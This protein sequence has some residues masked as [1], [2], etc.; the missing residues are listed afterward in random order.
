M[1][2]AHAHAGPG[3]A[4]RLV[5]AAPDHPG[6][7]APKLLGRADA[8]PVAGM[9]IRLPVAD[10]RHHLQVLGVTGTG[11]STELLA[12][13]LAEAAAGRGFALLD[14]K[15]DLARDLLA[16]LPAGAGRRLVLID[17]DETDAPAALNVLDTAGRSPELVAEHV[18]G[19]LHRLYGAYWGPRVEDTLRAAILTLTAH[20][21][22]AT[23]ADVPR[24][25]TDRRFR[26]R[27]AGPARADDPD[28][29]GAFWDAFDALSPA[30]AAAACGPVLSKLRAV[31]TRPFA[32]DLFGTATSTF[33]PREI[34]DGGILIARLPKGVIGEDGARLVGSLLLAALWQ[35][36]LARA[37][38]P[39]HARLDA[40]VI[41]DECHNFLHL[42]IGIDDALAEARGL[43][44]SFVLAHQHLGQLPGEVRDAVL[45]NARNKLVFTVSPDDARRLAEHLGPMLAA[46]DLYR[47]PAYTACVR[48]VLRGQDTGGF[49]LTTAPPPPAVPGRADRLRAAARTRGLPRAVR[50]DR[51]L[52]RRLST[53]DTPATPE[54]PPP[55]GQDDRQGGGVR[56]GRGGSL[57]G[58]LGSSLG[59]SPQLPPRLPG[60]P[61]PNRLPSRPARPAGDGPDWSV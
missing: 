57:V 50:E 32:A 29:L 14:P 34:L 1:T 41:V 39:E 43:R 25:L 61:T 12:L 3:P 48:L 16:R 26:T 59:G 56:G 4:G 7:R 22:G 5:L 36:A 17:P 24:L 8:E 23:L 33:D 15:G 49:T 31:L 51:R 6:Q 54:E 21:A 60:P 55:T 37:D 58:P 53:P 20:H 13:M 9:P 10:A 27:L 11:K 30:A 18:V 46:E 42:P 47:R 52:A 38:Q 19:V 28:G 35:A 2:T 44:V 45:A 40:S